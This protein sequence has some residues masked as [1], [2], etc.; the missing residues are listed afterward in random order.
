MSQYRG[1]P[2]KPTWMGWFVFLNFDCEDVL[3]LKNGT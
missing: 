1:N 3:V 2:E